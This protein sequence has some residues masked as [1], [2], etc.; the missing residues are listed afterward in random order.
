MVFH[1]LESS[2]DAP[3]SKVG[4]QPAVHVG[5]LAFCGGLPLPYRLAVE[6][7]RTEE[8]EDTE[9]MGVTSSGEAKREA[10][11]QTEL[12]PTFAETSRVNQS[13]WRYKLALVGFNPGEPAQTAPAP[14]WG[15]ACFARSVWS[16]CECF[17]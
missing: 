14:W 5:V 4:F 13:N 9:G 15:H 10:P 7:H 6:R 8:T 2:L 17:R 1:H 11:V 16:G 3:E 12:R